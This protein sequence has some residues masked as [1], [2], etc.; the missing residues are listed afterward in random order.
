[1]TDPAA[2]NQ[3]PQTFRVLVFT[4]V[5]DKDH[6]PQGYTQSYDKA[7]ENP[8]TALIDLAEAMEVSFPTPTNHSIARIETTHGA[9]L[10][11]FRAFG[12]KWLPLMY[13]YD[14]G[15]RAQAPP[16]LAADPAPP[17][18]ADDPAVPT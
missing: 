10:A 9:V 12:E 7:H 6:K 17:T 15:L 18:P 3:K 13:P 16:A 14:D 2:E 5:E 11:A 1:M 4:I 8:L